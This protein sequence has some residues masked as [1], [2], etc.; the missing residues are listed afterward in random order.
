MLGEIPLKPFARLKELS[1]IMGTGAELANEEDREYNEIVGYFFLEPTNFN[2]CE[3]AQDEGAEIVD[4]SIDH[5]RFM[6]EN[7]EQIVNSFINLSGL[8]DQPFSEDEMRKAVLL[9]DKL[10]L[11]KQNLIT[12]LQADQVGREELLRNS[13]QFRSNAR[14][15]LFELSQNTPDFIAS[16]T[17]DEGQ[18][19]QLVF[20]NRGLQ[21]RDTIIAQQ[22]QLGD[23]VVVLGGGQIHVE[24]AA[25]LA[26]QNPQQR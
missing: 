4:S 3:E 16:A 22:Q 19:L 25:N 1:R 20:G 26:G 2:P 8:A 24:Q 14:Q 12:I 10:S 23:D 18:E 15:E 11:Q 21:I 13:K 17:I 7:L 9:L 6:D 5:E